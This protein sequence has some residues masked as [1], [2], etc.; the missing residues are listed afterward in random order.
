[1][2]S[3]EERVEEMERLIDHGSGESLLD[4]TTVPFE[5][6]LKQHKNPEASSF[7][8][9]PLLALKVLDHEID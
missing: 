3:L 2:Y 1:M 5:N 8:K 6:S 7:F 9:T 4:H